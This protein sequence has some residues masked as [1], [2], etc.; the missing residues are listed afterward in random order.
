MHITREKKDYI[1]NLYIWGE[2]D[3]YYLA[4]SLSY[5]HLR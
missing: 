1:R 4:T 3:I 2:V 5:V